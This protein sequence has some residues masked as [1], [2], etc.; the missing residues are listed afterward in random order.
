[1]RPRRPMT[2][3]PIG[4]YNS[5][6]NFYAFALVIPVQCHSYSLSVSSVHSTDESWFFESILNHF[7]QTIVEDFVKVS[8]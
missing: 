1:M 2:D 4:F 3:A 5:L 8:K 7:F 6:Y